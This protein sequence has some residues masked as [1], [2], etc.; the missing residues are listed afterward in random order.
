MNPF[1]DR[2][3]LITGAASGI[4]R[5]LALALSAEGARVGAIDINGQGLKELA[6][7]LTG[8]PFERAIADVT[9]LSATRAATADLEARLGPSDLLAMAA[10]VGMETSALDFRA[11]KVAA[12]VNAN[13]LGVANCIDAALPGMRR[14]QCGHL[15]VLSSLASYRGLPRMAGYCASKAGLN[16]LCDGL[17]VELRPLGIAVTTI[18]P[19]WVRTPMTA[20]IPVPASDMMEVA[21]AARRIVRILAARKR[22]VAFPARLVWKVRL[23]SW[24]PAGWSD[25]V[26][27]RLARRTARR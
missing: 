24:L 2:V 13:L 26:V 10:G 20:N 21:E 22:F 7:Q 23:L 11:E 3:A 14:R 5:A 15:A 1:R 18:C 25:R 27:E 8:R 9:D 6:G 16:A 4:G 12:M 19:G 17:R